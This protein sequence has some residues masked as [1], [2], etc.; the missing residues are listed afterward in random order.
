MCSL[1]KRVQRVR[2]PLLGLGTLFLSF[3][4]LEKMRSHVQHSWPGTWNSFLS[5]WDLENFSFWDLAVFPILAAF[6]TLNSGQ[7]ERRQT[8]SQKRTEKFLERVH[9][10]EASV[11]SNVLL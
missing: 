3:W 9:L 4:D 2:V 8:F 7:A 11:R 6:H 1:K 10:R 5:F